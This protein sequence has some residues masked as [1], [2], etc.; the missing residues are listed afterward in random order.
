MNEWPLQRQDSPRSFTHF[1]RSSGVITPSTN[2]R[3]TSV[4]RAKELLDVVK[5]ASRS[6]SGVSGVMTDVVR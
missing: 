1:W 5:K 6:S 4:T 3:L 2:L